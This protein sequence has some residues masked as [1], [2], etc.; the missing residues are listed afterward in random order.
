MEPRYSFSPEALSPSILHEEEPFEC[1]KC[2]KPFGTKSTIERIVGQLAGKHDMFADEDSVS[3][4]KM[5]DDC[6]IIHQ[7]S[8]AND[9]FAMGGGQP[10]VV[11][12]EDYLEE[13]EAVKAGGKPTELTADDFLIK[14][15]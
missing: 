15:D 4:I 14:D 2:G 10:R 13:R 1:I 12:T 9:P 6:R 5:C 11:R 3:L 7:A 8:S